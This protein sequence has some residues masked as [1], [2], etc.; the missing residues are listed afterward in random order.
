MFWW[1]SVDASIPRHRATVIS[2]LLNIQTGNLSVAT[3]IFW[4]TETKKIVSENLQ[5]VWKFI[6][7]IENVSIQATVNLG[8]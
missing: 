5:F 2:Y 8:G 3:I 6:F 4:R 1:D 7:N